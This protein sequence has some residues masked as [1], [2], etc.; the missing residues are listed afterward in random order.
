MVEIWDSA[1]PLAED[2]IRS[3]FATDLVRGG[4]YMFKSWIDCIDYI[5]MG[6]AALSQA[7]H[8]LLNYIC[9]KDEIK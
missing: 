6:Y 9:Q 7:T 8:L 5:H 1:N 4:D 2:Y 3:C